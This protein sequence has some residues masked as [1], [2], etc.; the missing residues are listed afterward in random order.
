MAK[1]NELGNVQANCPDCNGALSIY[2]WSV[3]GSALGTVN[4]Q[5]P[6]PSWGNS[7]L[8]YRFFCCAG[9]G[10]GGLGLI[11]W[12][13]TRYPGDKRELIW[14]IPEAKEKLSL[15]GKVP[16]GIVNEF[17]E[18]EKCMESECHRAAAGMLRSVLDKTMKANGYNDKG[19]SLE[20]KIEMAANDRVITEARKRRAHE[21]IRVLGNDVLHDEWHPI[22]PEDPESARHY[23]QRILEDLYDDR[24][25]VLSLL[26]S[27]GRVPEEDRPA[28]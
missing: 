11:I 6:Y 18:A 22:P 8:D 12:H 9:C 4:K 7:I 26:R 3:G 24:E 25:S 21:E 13:G 16:E 20:K 28:K 23:C 10:R 27:A 19:V 15:P 14:F 5:T 1:I 17:R 2:E